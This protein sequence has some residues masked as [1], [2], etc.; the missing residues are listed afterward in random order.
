MMDFSP[1]P[2]CLFVCLFVEIA[3]LVNCDS[4][5]AATPE[6]DESIS[7]S[8]YCIGLYFTV[9]G[10]KINGWLPCLIMIPL[11][12]VY[13]FFTNWTD[14]TFFVLQKNTQGNYQK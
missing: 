7:V 3:Q 10:P 11:K 9:M 12:I 1:P 5:T 8:L 13:I 4:G 6:T 14:S 2:V